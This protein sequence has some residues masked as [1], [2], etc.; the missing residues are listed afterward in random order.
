MLDGSVKQQWKLTPA[1]RAALSLLFEEF[2][3]DPPVTGE[4]WVGP[5]M[6]AGFKRPTADEELPT[7]D[8]N[9]LNASVAR[10][11]R[12]GP[13][14]KPEGNL[15]PQRVETGSAARIER[16]PYVKAWVL[17]Q[18]DG[19][20]ECCTKQAPFTTELGPYLE[21]HHVRRLSAGGPD[22]P[23]NTVAVCPNCHRELHYGTRSAELEKNLY[24]RLPRLQKP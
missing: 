14:A 9:A 6:R 11:L 23:E 13:L 3:A 22:T 17:Q 2:L 7:A 16:D 10:I 1:G 15:V 19:S 24:R 4:P 20:C 8:E 12:S 21:V 18:A 5:G